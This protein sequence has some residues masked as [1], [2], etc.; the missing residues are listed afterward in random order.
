M[1]FILTIFRNSF[2][3]SYSLYNIYFMSPLPNKIVPFNQ[4]NLSL[5]KEFLQKDKKIKELDQKYFIRVLENTLYH[6]QETD[7]EIAQK[8]GTNRVQISRIKKRLKEIGLL[9]TPENKKFDRYVKAKSIVEIWQVLYN[10]L[11]KTDRQGIDLQQQIKELNDF[12]EWQN[13]QNFLQKIENSENNV[14][15]PEFQKILVD[16]RYITRK[17]PTTATYLGLDEVRQSYKNFLYRNSK[18][19]IYCFSNR[20]IVKSVFPDDIRTKIREALEVEIWS[21]IVPKDKIKPNEYEQNYDKIAQRR[22]TKWLYPE[23]V[24]K[25]NLKLENFWL[26]FGGEVF[27]SDKRILFVSLNETEFEQ[28]R[29]V[30]INDKNMVDIMRTMFEL[31]WNLF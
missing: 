18:N 28:S 25:H 8:I 26:N 20:Q 3:F 10:R 13:S 24:A 9:Q 5:V 27:I 15:F 19:K 12:A 2:K 23:S 21:I 7:E 6:R 1:F 16:S 11:D 4:K 31:L 17:P 22:Q 14:P 29:A 30:E